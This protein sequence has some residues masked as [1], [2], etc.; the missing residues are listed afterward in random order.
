MKNGI[1]TGF[2]VITRRIIERRFADETTIANEQFG[3]IPCRATTVLYVRCFNFL[4]NIG[5]NRK[6]C[7][8]Y[9]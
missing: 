6:D 7:V 4:R 2:V 9:L 3:P 8:W 5:E 1:A